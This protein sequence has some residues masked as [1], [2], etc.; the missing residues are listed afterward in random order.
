MGMVN[1]TEKGEIATSSRVEKIVGG[2][3]R[4]DEDGNCVRKGFL[5]RRWLGVKAGCRVSRSF[6]KT[7]FARNTDL[8]LT[9]GEPGKNNM[10]IM[11]N[12]PI[13]LHYSAG[14]CVTV[15]RSLRRGRVAGFSVVSRDGN[16]YEIGPTTYPF[17][18][19]EKACRNRKGLRFPR[20]SGH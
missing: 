4:N 11:K 16:C 7:E 18:L 5:T 9:C 15:N 20:K 14:H 19:R 17:S 8:P 2:S 12:K 6:R 1:E 13:S 3:P 10:P